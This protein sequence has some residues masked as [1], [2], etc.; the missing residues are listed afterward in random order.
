[1]AGLFAGSLSGTLGSAAS[2]PGIMFLLSALDA[3]GLLALLNHKGGRRLPSSIIHVSCLGVVTGRGKGIGYVEGRIGSKF[4][5]F[6]TC[7]YKRS[8]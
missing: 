7:F 6:L 5:L 8:K 3:I 1:M 4:Y 2:R